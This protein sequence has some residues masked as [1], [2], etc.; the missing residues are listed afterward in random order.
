MA[1]GSKSVNQF[2]PHRFQNMPTHEF[3]D[4]Q[5][6]VMQPND[7]AFAASCTSA[8]GWLSENR[9][10]LEGLYIKDPKGC[11]L[12]SKNDQPIG[13]C[14]AVRYGK[15]GFIG[16]LI[17]C[18]EA[19]G[20]GVGARL[21]MSGIDLMKEQGV[22]TVY[23]D[24]VLKA[25][26]LYER[27]GFRKVCRS[28]R[29]SG[30]LAGS[31]NQNVRRMDTSD[32]D[33]VVALDR[34]SFGE[35]RSFFLQ[36]RLDIYPKLSYVLLQNEGITG[37]IL[38][39]EGEDWVS[40]GPWVVEP[41]AAHPLELLRAFALE[42]GNRPIS[43]GILDTNQRA[44]ELLLS[45]GFERFANSPWRMALGASKDVGTSPRCYAIGSAAKG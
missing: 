45:A 16:E 31:V 13:I 6:R 5:I 15:S 27:H 3:L 40:A 38:G 11:L 2:S 18:R 32:L 35:D 22:E 44:C 9:V 29:F 28:W 26:D 34:V 19:R 23:L 42:A 4:T 1:A 33:Q 7:L 8:E 14:F 43:L 24:G 20:K 12:A 10:T 36:R 25:V 37:Y 17:V 21:L 39:R 41:D 30:R